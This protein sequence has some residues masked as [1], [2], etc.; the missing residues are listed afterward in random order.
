VG[1]YFDGVLPS[2][3]ASG[4][5]EKELAEGLAKTA[6]AAD[7]AIGGLRFHDALAVIDEYVSQVNGYLSDQEPWQVAKDPALRDRLAAILATAAEALRGIAVL[8]HPVL[9]VATE[10]LWE[11]LGA[12]ASLG[13]IGAQRVGDVGRWGQLPDGAILTKG[14]ALF[15]RLDPA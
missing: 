13:P 14:E 11:Q 10:R 6:A 1:R 3:D 2:R 5:A 8:L 15:P 7:A 4:P 12:E 9:P